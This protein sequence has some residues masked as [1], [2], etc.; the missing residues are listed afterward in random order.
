MFFDGVGDCR[1]SSNPD[2]RARDGTSA[3]L[4][5]AGMSGM[6]KSEMSKK[7]ISKSHL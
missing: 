3:I 4:I 1:I 5:E 2:P 6:S 7:G